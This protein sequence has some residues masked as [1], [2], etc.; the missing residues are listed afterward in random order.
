MKGLKEFL[1][2]KECLQELSV[3]DNKLDVEGWNLQPDN[4][5]SDKH[6]GR[7]PR[8]LTHESAHES[9]HESPLE[10]GHEGAHKH[11]LY[12]FSAPQNSP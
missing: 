12:L 3:S 10:G 11:S 7:E 5:N 9:A 1:K 8:S 4:R 6:R 2:S